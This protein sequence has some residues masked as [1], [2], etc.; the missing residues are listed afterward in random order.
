MGITDSEEYER[1]T[2]DAY[3]LL[4]FIIQGMKKMKK[5]GNDREEASESSSQSHDIGGHGWK[6]TG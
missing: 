1:I 5:G 6:E 2:R 3:E 4:Q